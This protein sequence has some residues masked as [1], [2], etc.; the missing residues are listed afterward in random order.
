[1]AE[2]F[3][4][5]KNITA[6]YRNAKSHEIL[7]G[8]SFTLNQ[9]DHV[10]IYGAPGAGKSSLLKLLCNDLDII[11]GSIDIDGK[12]SADHAS[13]RSGYVSLDHEDF[14]SS[15]SI[16]DSLVAFGEQYDIPHLPARIDELLELLEMKD[17]ANQKIQ[18]LSLTQKI[19]YALARACLS[20]S[21][22]LLLDDVLDVLGVEETKRFL[23]IAC[24]GKTVLLTT[25]VPQYAEQ[26][27][28]PLLLLHHGAVAHTGIK[29][30]IAIASGVP[31]IINAWVEALRYDTLKKIRSHSGVLEVRILPTDR[32]QGNLIRVMTRN[33]RFI[34]SL[35][36][37]MSQSELVHVEEVPPT[38]TDI[39]RTI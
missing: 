11:A 17:K 31:R 14:T 29:D 7:H 34:P 13:I 4:G 5:V 19:S 30:D 12:N 35:Y 2:S 28:L 32:F 39:L 27:N 20:S 38:L 9:G 3:V 10:V 23:H 37:L 16:Y 26:M 18:E 6:S 25:R 21:P 24:A 33:S 36:D 1:M 22:L 15:Y 8:I